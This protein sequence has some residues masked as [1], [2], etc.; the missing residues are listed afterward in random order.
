MFLPVSLVALLDYSHT[1]SL[2][3]LFTTTL[4]L[5]LIT[6]VLQLSS[7]LYSGAHTRL[8]EK[9]I[10]FLPVSLV[11]LLDYSRT[12]SLFSL[13]TTYATHTCTHCI[14]ACP[15]IA[16]ARNA[17]WCIHHTRPDLDTLSPDVYLHTCTYVDTNSF[18]LL[19]I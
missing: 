17:Q 18:I 2:F 7:P 15:I 11:A 8:P 10:M 4:S 6:I 9:H 12:N 19:A 13:F 16:Y 3:S 14:S 5:T 1:N